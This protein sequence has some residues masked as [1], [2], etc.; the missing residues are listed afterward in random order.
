MDIILKLTHTTN[1]VYNWGDEHGRHQTIK[2]IEK[3]KLV[4]AN[5]EDLKNMPQIL[6]AL[7]FVENVIGENKN[8]ASG[9]KWNQDRFHSATLNSSYMPQEEFDVINF[10][11]SINNKKEK[12]LT[13]II[14][15]IK[16]YATQLYNEDFVPNEIKDSL[17]KIKSLPDTEYDFSQINEYAEE[18]SKIAKKIENKNNISRL[19]K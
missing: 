2:P 3:S 7:L 12:K 6:K 19:Y 4:S 9:V 14:T 1:I 13:K 17:Y 5:S 8:F 18:L 11:C 16:E 10:N 15:Y